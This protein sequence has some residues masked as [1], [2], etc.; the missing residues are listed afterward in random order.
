MTSQPTR[1]PLPRSMKLQLIE[2]DL[3]DFTCKL[4]RR[5]IRGEKG[6]LPTLSFVTLNN[7]NR[8]TPGGLLAII[9]LAE[10]KNLS[11]NNAVVRCALVLN[12]APV[13]VFFAIFESPFGPEKN[14]AIV[15]NTGRKSR[16]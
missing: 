12:N 16:G 10:I 8:L 2:P 7:I 3:D 1:P 5:A 11:L 15:P 13:A 9:D 14:G 4:R 6:H